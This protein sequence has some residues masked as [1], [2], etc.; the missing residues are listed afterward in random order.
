MD[1]RIHCGAQRLIVPSPG[2]QNQHRIIVV[3]LSRRLIFREIYLPSTRGSD[4]GVKRVSRTLSS[5]PGSSSLAL[6][7][8]LGIRI[9]FSEDQAEISR[10]KP[11]HPIGSPLQCR[12]R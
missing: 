11:P 5:H 10:A 7:R 9:R 6:S 8:A 3:S 1:L 2:S 4:P 12:I